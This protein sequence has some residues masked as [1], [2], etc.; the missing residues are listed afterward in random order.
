MVSN[1]T[2]LLNAVPFFLDLQYTSTVPTKQQ[3]LRAKVVF[4]KIIYL[5]YVINL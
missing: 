1:T 4:Y 2:L 5:F 3:L